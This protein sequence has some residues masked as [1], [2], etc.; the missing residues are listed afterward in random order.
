[1]GDVRFHSYLITIVNWLKVMAKYIEHTVVMILH[2]Q[3][4]ETVFQF[5]QKELAPQ[6]DEIDKSN[7]FP[8]MKV[9]F[10]WPIIFFLSKISLYLPRIQSFEVRRIDVS[11]IGMSDNISLKM[12]VYLVS[13]NNIIAICGLLMKL[14]VCF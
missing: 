2:F 8:G 11:L 5:A 4:R 14:S 6:A 12:H 9:R 10:K 3:L 7:S 13:N 1:M